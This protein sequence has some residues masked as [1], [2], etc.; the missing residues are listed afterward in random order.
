M[1]MH[2]G[3][4][5]DEGEGSLSGVRMGG[6][7]AGCPRSGLINAL[8]VAFRRL[9]GPSSW[10]HGFNGGMSLCEYML[11]LTDQVTNKKQKA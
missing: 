6:K 11:G 7:R 8:C 10:G 5:P 4:S 2:P 1:I 3:V 9:P